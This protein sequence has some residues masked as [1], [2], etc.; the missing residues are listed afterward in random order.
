VNLVSSFLPRDIPGLQAA[1]RLDAATSGLLLI[2]N[3]NS[4]N[5]LAASGHGWEKE[6]LV[7]VAGPVSS[8]QLSMMTAGVTIANVGTFQAQSCSIDKEDESGTVVRFAMTE[9]KVRQIKT[10][11]TALHLRVTAMHRVRIGPIT[12]GVL[13]S[14]RLRTLST[15][16]V[17]AIA[18]GPRD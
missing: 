14:G 13:Q 9:G 1:G 18:N 12:L 17:D 11:F 16:E 7:T 5:A 10:L 15:H 6:F 2:S 8:A 4:W 3:D